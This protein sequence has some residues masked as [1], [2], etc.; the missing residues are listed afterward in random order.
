[1]AEQNF[2]D[3]IRSLSMLNRTFCEGD[4][5]EFL[6]RMP[7]ASVDLIATDPPFNKNKEFQGIGKA[8]GANFKD[9]WSW[10]DDVH[11]PYLDHIAKHWPAL[12]EVVEAAYA[13]HSPSMAAFLSFMS[14]RLI[15]MHRVLKPEGSIYVHCDQ[16]ANAYMRLMLDSIFGRQ[17]FRNEITWARNDGRGKG[18]QHAPKQWGV[19]TDSVLYYAKSS[20]SPLNPLIQLDAEQVVEKFPHADEKGRRYKTGIP[21]WCAPS[22]GPRPNLCYEWRGFTNPHPSGWRLSKDRMEE[23]YRKGNIVIK[24]NKIERRK[25]QDEYAGVPVGDLWLG[26]PAVKGS[27]RYGWPTQKPLALYRRIIEASSTADSLVLDPFAG[28]ATT[29]VA[30]EQLGRR[31]I[32]ID[33][34]PKA[35]GITLDRLKK[36]AGAGTLW[37]NE[38]RTLGASDLAPLPDGITSALSIPTLP[39]RVQRTMPK[40]YKPEDV[41]RYLAARE[42]VGTRKESNPACQGCGYA[43]PRLEYQDVDHIEPRASGGA[44]AWNNFCVL[45]RPCNRRKAHK[46]TIEELRAEVLAGDLM[47]DQ[48]ALM[49]MDAKSIAQRDRALRPLQ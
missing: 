32:G 3:N 34:S 4:N 15:E 8:E 35:R 9:Y 47:L 12:N 36:E 21:V 22:M 23:E 45:C 30:A 18:S 20:A 40:G 37:E 6:L 26:I 38:V 1:M 39:E 46:L 17:N 19:Q 14:V 41:R 33:I 25:Y 42:A 44:D 2:P 11:R 49:P 48:S 27:E 43:P 16:T 28:C 7:D 29:C 10:E 24:G 13:A 31:W 5:L